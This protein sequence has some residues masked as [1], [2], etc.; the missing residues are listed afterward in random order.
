MSVTWSRPSI[1]PRSTKAPNSA[2][3]LTTPVRILPGLD[4]RQQ[5]PP[6]RREL[7]CPNRTPGDDDVAP[8]RVDRED[9]ALEAPADEPEKVSRAAD[10]HLGGGQEGRDANVH[11]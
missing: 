1:P 4:L 2:M 5:I 9:L 6:D 11:L 3:F 7:D 10:I 8:R